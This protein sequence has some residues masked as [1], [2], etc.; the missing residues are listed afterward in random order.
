MEK[1]STLKEDLIDKTGFQNISNKDSKT[2]IDSSLPKIPGCHTSA[3]IVKSNG[4][5]S[6]I[7]KDLEISPRKSSKKYKSD[8]YNKIYSRYL[9]SNRT[10][11]LQNTPERFCQLWV[12]NP[13]GKP[14]MVI[15]RS[16]LG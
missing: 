3:H 2:S 12:S 5:T 1:V 16:Q 7:S 15:R 6:K 11:K 4:T 13:S 8:R 10:G 9:Q 14:G